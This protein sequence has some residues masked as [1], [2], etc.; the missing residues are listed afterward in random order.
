MK[1]SK[2]FGSFIFLYY[3]CI[4]NNT[5]IETNMENIKK[6]VNTMCEKCNVTKDDLDNDYNNEEF[7][8]FLIF[9]AEKY[10]KNNKMQK[11]FENI[12]IYIGETTKEDLKE[13]LET[14]RNK[15]VKIRLQSNPINFSTSPI[16]NVVRF[17]DFEFG[18]EMIKQIDILLSKL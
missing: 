10:Y 1:L 13:F 12:K 16:A 15:Y 9:S 2:I 11:F 5:Q 18:A 7:D 3:L 4:V 6:Y 8:L 14:S 17:W